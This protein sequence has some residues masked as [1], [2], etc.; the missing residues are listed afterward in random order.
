MHVTVFAHAA[1]IDKAKVEF[2]AAQPDSSGYFNVEMR[3]SGLSFR[4]FQFALRYDPT[5]AVP[6]DRSGNPAASFDA[7]ATKSQDTGW[8]STVG[9]E[10]NAQTGLIDLSAYIMPGSTGGPLN[11]QYEAV[12]GS[13]G[14]LVYTF[15]FKAIKTGNMAFQLASQEKGEP[16]RPACPEGVIIENESGPVPATLVFDIPATLG[17]S[18]TVDYTGASESNTQPQTAPT[19]D[20]LLGECLVLK[21]DS[22]VL[23]ANSGVTAFYPGEKT[24]VPFIDASNRTFVPLRFIAEKFGAKVEWLGDTRTAVITSGNTEIKMSIGDSF[25]YKNGVKCDMDCS[26]QLI[27]STSGYAR[28][29]VPVRF[30]AEALGKKVVWDENSH[31]VIIA[32]GDYGWDNSGKTEAEVIKK[33]NSLLTMYGNFV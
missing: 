25:Y 2:K 29:V 17:T 14:L 1:T 16:Y 13:D 27:G 19:A 22:S 32:P 33:A 4:V 21:I 23:V 6:V 11:G 31:F 24:V 18:Q 15:R 30:V 12:I 8:L 26:A 20:E 5:V 7:F 10:L 9:T 3:L 28:T